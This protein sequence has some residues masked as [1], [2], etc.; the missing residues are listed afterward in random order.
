MSV[1]PHQSDPR[2]LNR[3]TLERDHRQL[4]AVLRPGMKVLDVGCGTGAITA[5]VAKAVGPK[6]SVVGLDRDASLISEARRQFGDIANLS[7]LEGDALQMSFS[8]EF[9]V[10][11]AARALQWVSDPLSTLARMERAA[12]RT[13]LLVAL[14]YSHT[15]NAWEPEPP[16][17]FG[18]FYRAF[19]DWRAANDW[20]NDIADKLPDLFR[21][22][23]LQDIEVFVEDEMVARGDEA[24]DEACQ[25]WPYVMETLG[26]KV[27]EGGFFREDR[28]L[29]AAKA[30]EP[31]CAAELQR[32]TLAVR[33]VR[34]RV[35]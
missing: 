10:V 8:R 23:G 33:A 1:Q 15:R 24:F 7:F 28:R 29:A 13:G 27:V 4:A 30:M 31:W 3:R 17:A 19:L 14:D 2:I 12:A 9:D 5:G 11:T 6:G 34:G 26:P 18:E 22:I 16:D 21:R 35:A 20:H 32:Q 25:L